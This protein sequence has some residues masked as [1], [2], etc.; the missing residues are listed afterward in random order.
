MSPSAFWNTGGA[1]ERK[2]EISSCQPRPSA[3]AL[4]SDGET[5]FPFVVDT[6]A[7][8]GRGSHRL[9]A[10]NSYS[11]IVLT[12]PQRNTSS[13]PRKMHRANG[14]TTRPAVRPMCVPRTRPMGARGGLERI[15]AIGRVIVREKRYCRTPL[16]FVACSCALS[17]STSVQLKLT[18]AYKTLADLLKHVPGSNS[19]GQS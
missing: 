13:P 2:R 14:W 1:R 11:V 9:E 10:E 15:S 4:L 5:C 12:A 8:A 18:A 7:Y 3:R 17:I 19:G 16:I 6:L